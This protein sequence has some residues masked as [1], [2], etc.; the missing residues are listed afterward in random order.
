MDASSWDERYRSKELLWSKEPNRFVAEA[1]GSLPA[2][3]AVDVACGEGRNAIWL[4][5]SGW[6]VT[7][8]DFSAAALE[9]GRLLAEEAGVSVDWRQADVR[10]LDL[11]AGQF[12]LVLFSYLHLPRPEMVG[13]FQRAVSWLS[14]GGIVFVVAHARSNI[15]K[16]YGGPQDPGVLYEPEEVAQCFSPLAVSRAEH[17]FRQVETEEGEMTAI[18]FVV[19]A[20]SQPEPSPAVSPVEL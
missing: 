6:Q 1:L 4:A 9:R 10:R 5:A 16:G 2:G 8:A 3:R 7:A 13:L 20:S 12:D 19:V 17:V 18:D 11:P 14:P 15:E